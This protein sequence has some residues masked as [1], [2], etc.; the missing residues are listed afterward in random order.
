MR[1]IQPAS[2]T[3]RNARRDPV[4][5]AAG[6]QRDSRRPRTP[7]NAPEP[8]G[9]TRDSRPSGS[10]RRRADCPQARRAS[11]RVVHPAGAPTGRSRSTAAGARTLSYAAPAWCPTLHNSNRPTRWE[12]RRGRGSR[13]I[14]ASRHRTGSPRRTW[15]GRRRRRRPAWQPE[16]RRRGRGA[17]G[18]GPVPPARD[19]AGQRRPPR[20]ERSARRRR[21]PRSSG[22]PRAAPRGSGARAAGRASRSGRARDRRAWAAS[23]ARRRPHVRDWPGAR[24]PGT[25]R[26]RWRSR[27]A[28]RRSVA[29]PLPPGGNRRRRGSAGGAV[30]GA[31]YLPGSRWRATNA[32]AC[33]RRCRFS[34]ARM[35][36]T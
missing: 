21:S 6:M 9:S 33:V 35:L 10:A 15:P 20:S 11:G 16:S 27:P 22:P 2:G 18:R 19:R 23:S 36:L 14:R 32:G 12:S 3:P 31:D 26:G 1:C 7:R 25:R 17:G 5:S 13:R 34:L 4:G 8:G 30:D 29:R 24:T 28:C